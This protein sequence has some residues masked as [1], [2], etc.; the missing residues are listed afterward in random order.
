MIGYDLSTDIIYL[1]RKHGNTEKKET[2]KR[3]VDV[4][5]YSSWN[6]LFPCFR[7]SVAI[8]F[9]AQDCT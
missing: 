4:I 8:F 1:P 9:I 7:V 5:Y 3:K 6:T 2:R